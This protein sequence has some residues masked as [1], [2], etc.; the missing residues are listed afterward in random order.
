MDFN[1]YKVLLKAE[2]ER[3]IIIEILVFTCVYT[4]KGDWNIYTF[5]NLYVVIL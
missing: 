3:I 2:I 4:R 5:L 1:F